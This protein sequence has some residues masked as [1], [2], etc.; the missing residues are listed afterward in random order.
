VV[1]DDDPLINE[2]LEA[3]LHRPEYDV[4]SV[5]NGLD[6]IEIVRREQPDIVVLDLMLPRVDGFDVLEQ[7]RADPATHDV[8]VIVLTGKVLSDGEW[9]RLKAAAQIVIMKNDLTRERLFDALR[10][11]QC[12]MP[13]AAHP[14]I[15][16]VAS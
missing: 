6:A 16:E 1:V 15:A 8:P 13:A 12:R 4:T 2:L 11:V 7:L 14:A 5:V 10:S 3:M 9:E